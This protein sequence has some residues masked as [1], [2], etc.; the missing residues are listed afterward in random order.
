M[1]REVQEAILNLDDIVAETKDSE[2]GGFPV[3]VDPDY[4]A[5][6]LEE[7]SAVIYALVGRS[8]SGV[9]ATRKRNWLLKLFRRS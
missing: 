5:R 2:P 8:V 1:V 4:V 3:D 7:R 9:R 6:R